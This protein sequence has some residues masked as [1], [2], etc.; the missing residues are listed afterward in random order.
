MIFLL[1][2]SHFNTEWKG[3]RVPLGSFPPNRLQR[4]GLLIRN[5]NHLWQLSGDSKHKG[6]NKYLWLSGPDG[7]CG[8]YSAL[9]LQCNMETEGNGC[10]PIEHSLQKGACGKPRFINHGGWQLP[11]QI[12]CLSLAHLW[13][14]VSKT[15]QQ[16]WT[17]SLGW[18]F[19]D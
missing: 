17:L 15:Q 7:L 11:L 12:P 3:R 1:S 19:I 2:L 5:Q 9:S 18:D 4:Q 13:S 6:P 8:H 14:E 16:I 10:V